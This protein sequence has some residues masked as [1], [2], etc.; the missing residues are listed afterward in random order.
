MLFAR[1]RKRCVDRKGAAIEM[2]ILVL[3]VTFSLSILVLTT[4]MLQHSRKNRAEENMAQSIVLEQIGERFCASAGGEHTWIAQYPDYE[5]TVHGLSMSVKKKGSEN[6]LL[7]VAL[8][9]DGS[10][11]TISQWN[12]K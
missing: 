9:Y 7:T 8:S 2:A 1:L 5:I 6:V 4:A 10:Q 12:R 3:V 11:Y